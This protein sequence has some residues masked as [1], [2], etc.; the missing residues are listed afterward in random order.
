MDKD[1]RKLGEIRRLLEEAEENLLAAKRILFEQVYQEQAASRHVDS[2]LDVGGP[3]TII[4]GVFD[5]KEMID[6]A[7]RKYPVPENYSSKSKLIAGDNLKLTI[8]SDG[9]F[10]FKQI[11]PVERKKLI[12]KLAKTGERWQVVCDGKKYNCLQAAVTYYKADKGD[13]MTIIV[14]KTGESD[15]AAVENLLEKGKAKGNN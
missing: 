5:G 13:K 11:G 15:W 9:T 10:I 1:D 2:A 4:E 6:K 8:A 12:G 3:E 7:G 14:P